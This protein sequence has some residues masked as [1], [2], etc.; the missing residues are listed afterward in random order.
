MGSNVFTCLG[1]LNAQKL[2]PTALYLQNEVARNYMLSLVILPISPQ[3]VKLSML[4]KM[5]SKVI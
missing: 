4:K 2:S 3:H 5:L 1:F